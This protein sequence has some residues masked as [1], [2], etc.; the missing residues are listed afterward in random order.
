MKLQLTYDFNQS[1]L[2]RLLQSAL[3]R[4]GG[5]TLKSPTL[6]GYEDGKVAGYAFIPFEKPQNVAGLII[7]FSHEVIVQCLLEALAAEGKQIEPGSLVFSYY[8]GSGYGGGPR[9]SAQARACA[10]PVTAEPVTVTEGRVALPGAC[11]VHFSADNLKDM[12]KG[13]AR[14]SGLQ[15][16]YVSVYFQEA[17]RTVSASISVDGGHVSLDSAEVNEALARELAVRGYE[18]VPGGFRYN[19]QES[20]YGNPGGTSVTVSVTAVPSSV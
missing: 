1:E 14:K 10:E 8:P 12:L 11:T 2:T 4:R 13:I 19:H 15:P 20:S 9:L 16:T 7:D 18:V 17:D 6:R 3:N 5:A